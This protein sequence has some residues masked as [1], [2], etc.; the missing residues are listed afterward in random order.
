MPNGNGHECPG[1]IT[2]AKRYVDENNKYY[3]QLK[4]CWKRIEELEKENE[5]LKASIK[6]I[7]NK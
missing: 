4:E 6:L 5:T 3:R 2:L 7:Q 1:L